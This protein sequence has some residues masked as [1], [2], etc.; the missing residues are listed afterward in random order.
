MIILDAI[1]NKRSIT[2]D[3]FPSTW[4]FHINKLLHIIEVYPAAVSQ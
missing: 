1:M 4:E 2:N 3:N